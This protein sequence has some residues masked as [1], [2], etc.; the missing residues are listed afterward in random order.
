MEAPGFSPANQPA[1]D[2]PAFA[3]DVNRVEQG[4][5]P[6]DET[7]LATSALAAGVES[8]Q[9]HQNL[10]R[11]VSAGNIGIEPAESLQGRQ[12]IARH[13]SAGN[14]AVD[15]PESR[16]DDTLVAQGA[17]PG[18]PANIV[19][20][21]R[22]DGATPDLD[23][24]RRLVAAGKSLA[25]LHVHYEQ[26]PE[27]PLEKL[28]KPTAKLDYR[29]TK[30]RLSNKDKSTLFYNDAL[31]LKG[32]PLETSDY[33]LGNRSA[34]EWVIDQYQVSTDKRSG[35]TNDPNRADDREYILR[36]IGQVITVSLETVQIVKSLSEFVI[37]ETAATGS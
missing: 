25:D 30:M 29:V 9:G 24:F 5:S 34:L 33:R 3:A 22:R 8:R 35:I 17:S 20:E 31:T 11:H 32:I 37:S 28:W 4:F 13:I 1:S 18:N 7:I 6:A 14:S 2:S 12:S 26:Q 36:L 16:R 19:A 21:S 23:T 10:A 15:G 27:Y